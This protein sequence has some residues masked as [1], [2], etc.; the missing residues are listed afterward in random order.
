MAEFKAKVSDSLRSRMMLEPNEVEEV[1]KKAAV[2]SS[3]LDA[4]HKHLKF[5]TDELREAVIVEITALLSN[6]PALEDAATTE[7]DEENVEP[8]VAQ[9]AQAGGKRAKYEDAMLDFFGQDYFVEE[10]LTVDDEMERYQR[11]PAISPADDPAE[12][13]ETHQ[14]R[15]KNLSRLAQK[16]LCIPATSVPAERVFSA[17]GLIVNRLRTRLTPEHVDMLLFLN[18]N[19]SLV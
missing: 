4:R 14:G 16:Y 17:A 5:T 10:P 7:E 18:K 1:A 19:R 13:W 6:L 12:W 2:I 3:F 8:G 9:P 15:Y 11:E